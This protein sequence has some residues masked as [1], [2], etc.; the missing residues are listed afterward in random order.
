MTQS[1]KEDLID[2]PAELTVKAMGYADDAFQQIVADIV[3][4]HLPEHSPA[5]ITVLESSKGKYVS[6]RAT[7]TAD[8]RAQLEKIYKDLHEND[9]VLYTL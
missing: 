5:D 4:N 2:F 8:S 7:F 6:I 1:D 9:K 3:N